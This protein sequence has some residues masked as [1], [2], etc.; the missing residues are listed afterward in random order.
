M[1]YTTPYKK[2]ATNANTG[3]IAKSMKNNIHSNIYLLL[4]FIIFPLNK[5]VKAIR[6]H[7]YQ[8]L[9]QETQRLCESLGLLSTKVVINDI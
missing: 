4:N 6:R 7:L 9:T 8:S 3:D 5:R 1:K 2:R